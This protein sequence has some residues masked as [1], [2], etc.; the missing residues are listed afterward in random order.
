MTIVKFILSSILL[1]V[2]GPY[3][4]QGLG[5]VEMS[6]KSTILA[7]ISWAANF[8]SGLGIAGLLTWDISWC[9]R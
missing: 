9:P 8:W 3:L 4:L 6:V 7:V 5:L 2:V 1:V